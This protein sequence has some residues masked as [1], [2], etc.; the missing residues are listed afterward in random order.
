MSIIH[1]IFY[2]LPLLFIWVE[3]YHML[4]KDKIYIRF[5]QR[6]MTKSS[7]VDY[8]Y[9]VSKILYL[10]WLIIGLFSNISY[11]FLIIIV[12]SLIKLIILLFRSN[13]F[14]KIYD[15]VSSLLCITILTY[16]MYR[17]LSL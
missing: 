2:L 13:L 7:I 6:D 14:N 1:N 16:I 9:Y 11:Y 8:T 5:N 17:G 4:N 12:I 3:I 10:I 15:F